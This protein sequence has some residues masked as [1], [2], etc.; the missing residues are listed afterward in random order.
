M[1]P[2]AAV[3]C[4]ALLLIL[5]RLRFFSQEGRASLEHARAVLGYCQA[6]DVAA[7]ET[8]CE[9]KRGP[10]V[11]ALHACLRHRDQSVVAM[12]DSI[13]EAILHE[14]PRLERF[15]SALSI[16]ATVAPL[17]GLLGTITGMMYTF[18][19]IAVHGS[20]D[21][22][23]MAGGISEALITTEAGLI[24]AIPILLVHSIL[25]G[26]AERLIA[27]TERFAASLLI[28]LRDRALA[29]GSSRGDSPDRAAEPAG[30]RA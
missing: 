1:Y 3:A 26:K 30:G 28:L 24:I 6:G 2:L 8:Y 17:L 25:A 11:R 29:A 12:E 10:V 15:L 27:E 4:L 19:M 14:L 5:E 16:L 21:A 18:D 22:R 7:A 23:L 9:G 20:G 13:Q